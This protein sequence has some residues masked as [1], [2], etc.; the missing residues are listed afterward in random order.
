MVFTQPFHE[1]SLSC[2]V[3]T[4]EQRL[5]GEDVTVASDGIHYLHEYVAINSRANLE[6]GLQQLG[7]HRTPFA[8]K[9]LQPPTPFPSNTP[10]TTHF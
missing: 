5:K 10:H 6:G 9:I 4:H 7:P 2:T 8:K 3:G 1:D